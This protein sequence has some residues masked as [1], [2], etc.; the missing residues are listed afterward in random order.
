MR[1]EWPW[2]AG[3][4]WPRSIHSGLPEASR[5]YRARPSE[6]SSTPSSACSAPMS[7]VFSNPTLPMSEAI[8][9]PPGYSLTGRRSRYTPGNSNPRTAATWASVSTPPIATYRT[10]GAGFSG[11]ATAGLPPSTIASGTMAGV[12]ASRCP[13]PPSHERRAAMGPGRVT[14]PAVCSGL[15]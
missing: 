3:V 4:H 15:R 1:C 13:P 14:P 11:S 5:T 7:P 2:A 10:S 9:S 12:S 8:R 6:A